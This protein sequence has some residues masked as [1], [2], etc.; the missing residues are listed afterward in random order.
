VQN[1]YHDSCHI[2]SVPLES[3]YH[4]VYRCGDGDYRGCFMVE[5][6]CWEGMRTVEG[7]LIW[8]SEECTLKETTWL[9]YTEGVGGMTG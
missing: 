8:D 5:H 1:I 2:V 9:F 3:Y 4:V 6:P 7:P